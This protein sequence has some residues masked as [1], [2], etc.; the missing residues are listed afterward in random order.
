MFGIWISIFRTIIIK[1]DLKRHRLFVD[2]NQIKRDKNSH[3]RKI[4]LP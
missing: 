2:T 1:V 3:S 4:D